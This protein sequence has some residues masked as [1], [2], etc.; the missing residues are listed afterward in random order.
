MTLQNMRAQGVRSL[1]VVYEFCHRE[2][3]MNI[4]RFGD[5]VSAF[6]ARQG[7]HVVRPCWRIRPSELAGAPGT[8]KRA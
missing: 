3:V 5:D 1:W 4:D 6:G 2:T 8:S 7:L